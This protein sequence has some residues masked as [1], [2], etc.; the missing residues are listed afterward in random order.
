M[1][2]L[3]LISLFFL[4]FKNFYLLFTL[5]VIISTQQ[6]C[7]LCFLKRMFNL[8]VFNVQRHSVHSIMVS[9]GFSRF[10]GFPNSGKLSTI[11]SRV[12]TVTKNRELSWI[13]SLSILIKS[14]ASFLTFPKTWVH[15][16]RS[17]FFFTLSY[18]WKKCILGN[19]MYIQLVIGWYI[20]NRCQAS[21][22]VLCTVLT[23]K[24][25]LV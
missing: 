10:K 20:Q 18:L 19:V 11:H 24:W 21:T 15:V 2:I 9:Q 23:R 13:N 6:F 22:S 1:L 8:S 4:G 7:L 16:W 25:F 3:C 17:F 5:F 14:H 12:A